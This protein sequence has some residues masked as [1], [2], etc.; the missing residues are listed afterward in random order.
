MRSTADTPSRSD[1]ARVGFI[2]LGDMG[3]ALATRIIGAGF[4]TVLWA[5]RRHVLTSFEEAGAEAAPTPADLAAGVDMVGICVW[6]DDAVRQ[7][8]NGPQGVLAGCRPGT[9]VAIHSTVLPATCRELATVAADRGVVVVDAPVSGGRDVALAGKLVVA[10]GGDEGT[11]ARI[12]PVLASFGDPVIHVGR[13]GTGQVAK[14]VNN[15]L[16]AANLALADDALT[17]AEMLGIPYQ[18]IGQVLRH[19]S[20]RSFALEVAI[21]GRT[22]AEIREQTAVPLSKDVRCLV[23]Q[24]APREC[25]EVALFTRAARAGVQRV[26]EPMS[27]G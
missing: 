7:V 20:G 2:G 16:L 24:A 11:V 21:A 5:R 19:G 1:I 17:L 8:M 4:P 15:N 13:V 23:E 6:D 10:V 22:S 9:V 18:E 26:A 12:G 25:A 27:K 3:G 14:L